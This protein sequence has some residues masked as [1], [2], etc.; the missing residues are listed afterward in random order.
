[1]QAPNTQGLASIAPQQ[2][3]PP[4]GQQRPAPTPQ[5]GSPMA[6]LGSVENRVAAY[7]G[8]S[9]PLQQRYAMSQDLLDLL[10]LQKIKSEK[11]AAARQM[12]L[13][14]GQQQAAQ[15]GEPMTVAQQREKEV[16]DMTK[17]ELAQQRGATAEQQ[18]AEQQQA[19]QRMMGGIASA[20]GAASAAQPKMMASG[21]IVAF[22]SGGNE[23]LEE[24][25]TSPA[26]RMFSKVMGADKERIERVML[27]DKII[28][29]YRPKAGPVGLFT[30]QSDEQRAQAKQIME[31][32][33]S[34]S[35]EEMK[36]LL[37]QPSGAPAA[38]TPPMGAGAGRG[39]VNPPFDP[40]APMPRPP[41]APATSG[42]M[43]G[44]AP[45]GLAGMPGAAPAGLA[46]MPG[47]Q[48][49]PSTVPRTPAAPGAMPG[50]A[51]AAPGLESEV[52]K[53][54]SGGLG[55][56]AAK[57]GQEY[58]KSVE[59][60]LMF[61]EEQERRRKA[62][63]EQRKLYEQ[64]F[65]PERQRKE[66]LSRFLLGAGG[67]RYG[68]LA[69][70]A[71][72]AL[73][74]ETSQRGAQR[75]RLKG[76][77]DMEQGLFSL[78]KGATETGVGAESKRM[79]E[80]EDVR[81]KATAAGVQQLGTEKSA[82]TAD[83][84]RASR[85]KEAAMNRQVQMAQV[86]ATKDTNAVRRGELTMAQEEAA[87][88]RYAD[89]I[90]KATENVNKRY[91]DLISSASTP[92]GSGDPKKQQQARQVVQD[93]NTQREAE[94]ATATKE[95]REFL[96]AVGSKGGYSATGMPPGFSVEKSYKTP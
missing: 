21:G 25:Q 6:G 91:A 62:I 24:E 67:R 16:M 50:V 22:Q 89:M 10:A 19:M 5:S 40:N 71:G 8:D 73:D 1:M 81:A 9:A 17:N 88:A 14:M 59:E 42:A 79:G 26:G 7:R 43:P 36:A 52:T 4:Q 11:D 47:A 96:Q 53:A 69:G 74:Y 3:Q 44:A 84:D 18:T 56:D 70:G 33:D 92:L 60:R 48:G 12:Q 46:G 85:E 87:R 29:K 37:S 94:I 86:E 32:L 15:G 31:R 57:Q 30:P 75:E 78:R 64:E 49:A 82:E 23:G 90:L 39:M 95:F 76:L 41:A 34:M 61:P 93:L 66:G 45:A 77:E 55:I 35:T 13:Q 38:P 63:E 80:L 54:I 68:V 58:G 65:D 2:M 72:A 20:P 51:P 28:D 83:K 27:R